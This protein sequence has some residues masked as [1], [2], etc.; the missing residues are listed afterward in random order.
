[1]SDYTAPPHSLEAEH[2]VLGGCLLDA[3]A[4]RA[5]EPAVSVDDF[6][7]EGHRAI[8][9]AI[10]AVAGRGSVADLVTVPAELEAQGQLVN[11]G[12]RDYVGWLSDVVP[13]AANVVYHARVVRDLAAKRRLGA[14]LRG[15]ADAAWESG[16]DAA[17]L[18]A[19]AVQRLLPEAASLQRRGFVAGRDLVYDAM[20]AIEQ[21]HKGEATDLVTLGVPEIDGP[22]VYGVEAG[23]L[24]TLLLVSGH[25]KTALQLSLGRWAGEAGVEWGFVSAE[26]AGRQLANRLLSS[27]SGVEFGRLRKGLIADHEFPALAK[28]AGQVASLPF[29]VD[30]T[31]APSLHDVGVRVRALKAKHPGLRLVFVDYVQLLSADAETRTLQIASIANGM[32]ALA[33]E[34]GIVVVQ[35]AQPDARLVDRRGGDDK[36]PHIED[37]MWGQD[38]RFAS[39]LVICGYRPGQYDRMGEDD[40]MLCRVEKSRAS[41]GVDFWLRW[42]GPTM[43]AWSPSQPAPYSA[44]GPEPVRFQHPDRE[45]A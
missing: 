16:T 3:D 10:R 14:T 9:A 34:C 8:Y 25:G 6:Y 4:V 45:A 15:L 12:G 30:D 23:D 29:H 37:I 21:R 19:D 24:V 40:R 18:A 36:M 11:A 17:T 26:M 28:A 13:T 38:I 7:R 1:V 2:A 32:K 5:V 43:T 27:Y 42:S 33:K 44:R 35:S 20:L 22:P 41:N 39:D 31:P